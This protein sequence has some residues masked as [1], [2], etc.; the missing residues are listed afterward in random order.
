MGKAKRKSGQPAPESI[1]PLLAPIQA[2]QNLIAQFNDQGVIIGGV[3]ASLMGTPRYTVDLDAVFLLNLEDIPGLLKAAAVQG[4]EPR[5]PD[6]VGFARKNRILLLRHVASGTDIDLSLGILPFEIEMVE[7]STVSEIGT[8]CL[9][10][11]TPEDLIILKAV[12]HRPKDLEDIQAI[13]RSHPVMDMER[14]KYW[15]KQFGEALDLPDLW[16]MISPL[17]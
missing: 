8:L 14:I 9:R 7:R 3:A 15:V 13:A 17:L 6:P 11:P 16:S 12:A 10:L 2:L 1:N 5:I 4:I